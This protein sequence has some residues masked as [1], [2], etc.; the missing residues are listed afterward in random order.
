GDS[1]YLGYNVQRLARWVEH[2]LPFS[3]LLL[4]FFV[5]IWISAIMCKSND[6]LDKQTARKAT[7]LG[8]RCCRCHAGLWFRSKPT[9][10][11][12]HGG[13]SNLHITVVALR[14]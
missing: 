10:V 1:P 13:C 2:A 5:M 14:K 7:W 6:T 4:G 8:K 11:M 9:I 12:P 3:L